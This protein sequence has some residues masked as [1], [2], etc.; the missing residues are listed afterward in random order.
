[1][2]Q[3]NSRNAFTLIELIFV[4]ILVAL[5]TTVAIPKVSSTLGLNIKSSVL[6]VTGFLQAGYQ[7]AILTHKKIRVTFNMDTGQYWAENMAPAESIPLINETTN[8]D[9]VL[10]TFRKREEEEN[11]NDPEEIKKREEAKFQKIESVV[12]KSGQIEPPLK[13]KSIIFP[14][15]DKTETQGTV[16]F[17]ISGSGI[18]EEVILYIAHGDS[19]NVYS[20]IFPPMTGKAK[21]EKGEYV[22]S[23]K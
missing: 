5:I 17:F 8:L 6:R 12:L 21:I 19:D 14:G 20:I 7:Q 4:I 15:E 9:E 2:N 22:A 16:S 1:M 3:R 23:K 13:I 18:N 11:S 10:N